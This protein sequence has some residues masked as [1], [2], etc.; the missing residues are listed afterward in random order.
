MSSFEKDIRIEKNNL[1]EALATGWYL[2]E[3][4]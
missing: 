3:T 1:F 2:K 4:S